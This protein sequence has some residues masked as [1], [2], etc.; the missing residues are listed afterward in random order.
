V[1]PTRPDPGAAAQPARDDAARLA[2]LFA[3]A[4]LLPAIA[5]LA[6]EDHL[7]T[8]NLLAVAPLGAA[9]AG[10]GLAH[11]ERL[12]PRLR[13]AALA[14]ACVLG[15]AAVAGVALDPRSQRDDW[16]GA[17]RALGTAPGERLIAATPASA[18][19]PL[20]Y[21]MPGAR[22]VT[23]PTITTAEVDFIALSERSPGERPDPPRP[24]T[25]PQIPPYALVAGDRA[26]TFTVLRL[27][28]PAPQA[29]P[30]TTL[31]T[32]LD[33]KVPVLVAFTRQPQM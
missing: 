18:L 19:A 23:E 15:L 30:T 7:I 6:G 10:A 21:Y 28:A 31:A 25:P 24:A 5:A 9:L 14:S 27:R 11:A 12:R 26:E 33:G 32:G 29:L 22:E 4:L 17:V 2:A 8:R 16:R 3:A 20:R 1:P 13:P